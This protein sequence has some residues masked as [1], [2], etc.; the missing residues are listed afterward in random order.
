MAGVTASQTLPFL[1]YETDA[2]PYV[3]EA[4]GYPRTTGE[5]GTPL[6]LVLL[7]T[8]DLRDA[9]WQKPGAATMSVYR[10]NGTVFSAGSTDWVDALTG[11]PQYPTEPSLAAI[12]TNVLNRLSARV[13]ADWEDVGH[14]NGGCAMTA[15]GSR[16]FLATT[17]NR[18]WRRHPVAAEIPW[19]EVGHADAVVALASDGDV[20]YGLTATD[21]LW[22]R[23]AIEV[24]TTWTR[25]G[26]GAGGASTLAFAGGLLYATD[27]AGVMHRRPATHAAGP[28]WRPLTLPARSFNALA[29]FADIVLGTTADGRLLRTN[30]DHIAESTDW[31]DIHHCYFSTGLA[32]VGASLF[33]ATTENKLWWLDLHGLRQ[34]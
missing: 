11:Q 19:R 14:A 34:P 16:L 22:W 9:N 7:G 6:T 29:S 20:L 5:E 18:L 23:P 3:E 8:A 21:E 1:G 13:P 27:A 33:V 12:T 2:A 30:K 31:V 15:V 28:P 24:D 4:E 32:A 10:R 25:M 26:G 17:A